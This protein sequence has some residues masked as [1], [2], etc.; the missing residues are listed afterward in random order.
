MAVTGGTVIQYTDLAGIASNART[1][2]DTYCSYNARRSHNGA[3]RST[4]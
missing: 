2:A 1:K 3:Q 4:M